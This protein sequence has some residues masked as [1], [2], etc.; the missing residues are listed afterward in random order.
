MMLS[1]SNPADVQ[2]VEKYCIIRINEFYYGLLSGGSSTY[3]APGCYCQAYG[4]LYS[5]HPNF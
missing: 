3:C 2:T 1:Y 5:Q 4:G